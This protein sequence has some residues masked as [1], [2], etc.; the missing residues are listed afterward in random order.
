MPRRK[1]PSNPP[2]K[3]GPPVG[4]RRSK[5]IEATLPSLRK[6][7]SSHSAK[8]RCPV[9]QPA[10]ETGSHGTAPENDQSISVAR[11]P[12]IKPR[13]RR[14]SQGLTEEEREEE[15]LNSFRTKVVVLKDGTKLDNHT[16][17]E[18][19]CKG[20]ITIKD[21]DEEDGRK[22]SGPFDTS[23]D[24]HPSDDD[25]NHESSPNFPSGKASNDGSAQSEEDEQ[26]VESVMQSE[27]AD[28][29]DQEEGNHAGDA[30]DEC[31][32]SATDESSDSDWSV[33]ER[34]RLKREQTAREIRA[35]NYDI[36]THPSPP[37]EYP[38]SSEDTTNVED[39]DQYRKPKRKSD[40]VHTK[41]REV[42]DLGQED[43]LGTESKLYAH[44][45]GR[46]PLAAIKKAQELGMHTAKE[47]QA[48][49]DEYGKTLAS[50]MAAAGL[51]TR[52]T[53]AES[54]WNMHQA[55][56][57][58]TNPKTSDE[59]MKDYY[60]H[61][62]RHYETHKDEEEFPDLWVEIRKFWSESVSG[63]K[64][65]SS[66]AM[67]GRVM[68]CRDSFTQAAQ[69]WCNVENIH[70]FGCVIYSGNDEAARQAQG[71]FLGS[72]LCTQLA[73][74]R[75]TDVARLLDYLTAIIKYKILDSTATIPLPAF[76]MLSGVPYDH[77]LALKPQESTRDRNRR[78][79][80]LVVMHKLHEVEI[81]RGQ[82]N[83]PWKTLLDLLFAHKH[84]IVDWPAGVPAI[85]QDFNVK[86]LTADELR[87]LTVPFLKE[88]MG[89]DY[90]VEAAVEGEDDRGDYIVPEP[91]SSFRLKPWTTDQLA[92]VR[93]MDP[94]AFD[95]P[96]VIDT[97]GQ[98][99]RLLSDLQA[100]LKVVPRGM[101]REDTNDERVSTPTPTPSSPPAEV[102]QQLPARGRA[103]LQGRRTGHP[104]SVSHN[105]PLP[106]SSPPPEDSP[107]SSPQDTRHLSSVTHRPRYPTSRSH[108]PVPRSRHHYHRQPQKR[109]REYREDVSETGAQVPE[110]RTH[111]SVV[112]YV[113]RSPPRKRRHHYPSDEDDYP[114]KH[115][116]RY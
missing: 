51:T 97:L 110:R 94:G 61:Q 96:L 104:T 13:P 26:V 107:Q 25:N 39:S 29:P 1:S 37:L 6:T 70:V 11:T 89:N 14:S 45:R 88:Q 56:Y 72:S 28:D 101:R 44:K 59:N 27:H 36:E 3:I 12:I 82:R 112:E 86:R 73:A 92:L 69:T 10:V 31:A 33:T 24:T 64:D 83:V 2:A 58:G 65:V 8:A 54:V 40:H 91:A 16:A 7:Q 98:P 5:R 81:T 74:E 84:T 79:L 109:H 22:Q 34:C 111:H 41:A 105:S 77:V 23:S 115:H 76:A 93:V 55:W 48:I 102:L 42:P 116:I 52:A 85:N 30:A 87:A 95:I 75:Q 57:A 78:V 62:M 38:T 32:V 43:G 49:A 9:N 67:V 15:Y 106:P 60:C 108:S 47:A 71:I 4:V 68:T 19:L 103:P 63:T 99:L 66:K 18:L 90:H 100:F 20:D 114:Y 35:G 17:L 53:R 46:L 50:I 21:I 113:Y 80:P